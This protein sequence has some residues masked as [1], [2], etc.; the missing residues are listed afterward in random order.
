[1]YNER[2]EQ[3]RALLQTQPFI[4]LKELE[5]MFPNVSGMTLRR[6]I[7]YFENEHEAIKVRG[8]AKSMKF[9]TTQTDGSIA[10]R[11]NV[12]VGSKNSIAKKA[13]EF[14]ETGRSIFI[15]SGSTL[16]KLVQFVPNDRY[17]F[18]TTDPAVAIELSKLGLSV[19]NMVGGRL[20]R[21]NQTITGLQATRFL[22]DINIDIAFLS[23]SGL[24]ARSGF[25]IGNF[26]ECELKRIVAD[27]AQF[28]VI[29]MDSS[30]LNKA[31][32]YTFATL[33]NVNVIITDAP[34]TGD[35]KELVESKGIQIIDVSQEI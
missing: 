32:P 31:L 26:S 17:T 5:K 11:L 35:L 24:S 20:D 19:V 3:I 8:G 13:A 22:A 29:L 10:S 7:E 4:S 23:P 2:R 9:I 1:M 27:K 33:D 16:Q 25:T 21:D 28:V 14:L 30:K 34:I 18:T 6:D 15:D 12:N